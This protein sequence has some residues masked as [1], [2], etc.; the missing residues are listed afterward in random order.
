MH[1][2]RFELENRRILCAWRR[3]GAAGGRLKRQAASAASAG[4]DSAD[5]PPA[6]TALPAPRVDQDP[7]AS[8]AFDSASANVSTGCAPEIANARSNTKNGTPFAP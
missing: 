5:K 1:Q 7:R 4:A 6:P 8:R 3:G 2:A